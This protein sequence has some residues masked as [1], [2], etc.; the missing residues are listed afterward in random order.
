[1]THE[2]GVVENSYFIIHHSPLFVNAPLHDDN[3]RWKSV[4]QCAAAAHPVYELLGGR[5]KLIVKHPDC[6]H[7]F[8]EEL[9]RAAYKLIDSVL[10]PESR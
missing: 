1:M 9:R 2:S 10:R 7:D 4:E 3:F 6:G 5:G 8:P